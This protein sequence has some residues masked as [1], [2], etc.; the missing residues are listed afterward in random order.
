MTNARDA[1][2]AALHAAGDSCRAISCDVVGHGS[3]AD[4]ILYGL[5]GWGFEVNRIP[6][7]SEPCYRA[8]R[9]LKP[10]ELTDG[11]EGWYLRCDLPLDH[12][13]PHMTRIDSDPVPA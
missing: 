3:E 13:G 6:D 2:A 10:S 8:S 1:L 4:V 9:V 11:M 5:E 7:E 12:S